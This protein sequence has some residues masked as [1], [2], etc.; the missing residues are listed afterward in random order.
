MTHVLMISMDATLLTGAIGDSRAR[1]IEYAQRA[2]SLDIVVCNTG[3]RLD[4]VDAPPLRIVPTNSTR[5]LAYVLDGYR[6][7]LRLA[8][9][10]RP[11]VITTQDPFIT[12]IIGLRLRRVLG[13]PLIVQNASSILESAAFA[14]ESRLNRVLQLIARQVVRRADVLRVLNTSERSAA[15]RLGLPAD[16]VHVIPIPT[17]VARFAQPDRRIDWRARLGLTAEDR[18]ALWVGR[19]VPVKN[20]PLLMAA[21]ERVAAQLPTA[22]LVLAGDFDKT[23]Y[24]A[25]IAQSGLQNV[26]KLAGRVVHADLPS[27]YQAANVYVHSSHYEGLG[28]VLIEAAAAGLPIVAVASDG[29]HDIVRHGE[30]GLLVADN[31]VNLADDLAAALLELLRDPERAKQMG[32]HARADV[33]QRYD[34]A[35]ITGEWVGLWQSVATAA[36]F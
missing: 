35:R 31:A 34:P 10:C 8:S 7:G 21:F 28:L 1:H 32:A 27:L 3:K 29:P 19:A 6:A 36:R 24:P 11:D 17:D 2:G 33:M 14:H 30:S 15:I 25:Q 9:E 23:P 4:A 13:V 20:I 12:G 16:R 26:I 5:R 22:R 18:V